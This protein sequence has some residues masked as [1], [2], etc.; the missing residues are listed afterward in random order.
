[1]TWALMPTVDERMDPT[2]GW[3]KRAECQLSSLSKMKEERMNADLTDLA[4]D[5]VLANSRGGHDL[6]EC[7]ELLDPL[8][9]EQVQSVSMSGQTQRRGKDTLDNAEEVGTAHREVRADVV[10]HRQAGLFHLGLED[11]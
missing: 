9:G 2:Q 11:V 7:L 3:R 1:M 8:D 6:P 5:G 10:G 4:A